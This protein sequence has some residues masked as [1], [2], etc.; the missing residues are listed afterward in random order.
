MRYA[1]QLKYSLSYN[2][3][4]FREIWDMFTLRNYHWL[5]VGLLVVICILPSIFCMFS[6][7]VHYY[8]TTPPP[9][10]DPTLPQDIISPYFFIVREPPLLPLVINYH[11]VASDSFGILA[12]VLCVVSGSLLLVAYLREE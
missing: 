11:W 8:V 9:P 6:S 2:W 12:G 5:V 4:I 10:F 1:R 3:G 7:N